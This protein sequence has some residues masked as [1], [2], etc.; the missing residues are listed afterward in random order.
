MNEISS[1]GEANNASNLGNILGKTASEQ[2]GSHNTS[3]NQNH[4]G[5][6]RGPRPNKKSHN[7]RPPK[8]KGKKNF[9]KKKKSNAPSLASQDKSEILLGMAEFGRRT[10]SGN[11][12][13]RVW[14]KRPP[15]PGLPPPLKNGALRIIT[16][17][18]MEA[19]G[20]NCHLV[21][22][23]NDIVLIDMG[24][25]FPDEGM[26]GIDY[27][28]PD[29]GYLKGKEK[30]VKAVIVTHGHLD[31]IGGIPHLMPLIGVK[32]PIYGLPMTTALILKRQEEFK[33]KLN[34]HTISDTDV[35]QHGKMRIEFFRVNHNIPDSMGVAITTPAGTVINTG[36]WKIDHSPVNEKPTDLSKIARIGENNNVLAAMID[37][38]SAHKEGYQISESQIMK[39]LE[40]IFMQAEGRIIT[41]T[42]SSL[43]SRIQQIIAL[44]A[45]VGRKVVLEGRSM[46]ENVS[47]A[48]NL[49]YMEV[50]KGT[51][52]EAKDM[53]RYPPEK[54]TILSTGAQGER[55]AA[56]SR[57]AKGEHQ[58]IK[59]EPGDTV[60]FSSSY[61]PGNEAAIQSLMDLI[62]RRKANV[63]H[64]KHMDIHA[65]GH[66]K[67]EETKLLLS[68]LK[69]KV[70]IPIHGS[71][72]LLVLTSQIC[73]QVGY[74]PGENCH[75]MDNGSV[76][77]FSSNGD[78]K[79]LAEK[80]PHS[81]IAV[82]GLGVGDVGESVLKDRTHMGADGVLL[83]LLRVDRHGN[84]LSDPDIVSRGFVFMHGANKLIDTMKE[85]IKQVCKEHA[86]L[87]KTDQK[88]FKFT[89][90]KELEK[91]IFKKIERE[92][93][94]IPIITSV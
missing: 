77:D 62:Y 83:A 73:R 38:T 19:I 54:L 1:P 2:I 36:D 56:L 23:E 31:H 29:I 61:I 15:K 27:S 20:R 65:G 40:P 94:V 60:I 88:E 81:L 50:P 71:H 18:G 25:Q 9:S 35:L 22:Y 17:G 69:P 46:K 64:Y 78:H 89:L 39:N 7:N 59:I 13:H 82:D 52:I 34:I 28:I 6:N 14:E 47:I 75:V 24:L 45:K 3:S 68:L 92:P 8:Q 80:A 21:E 32:V 30:N 70:V 16:L 4:K 12:K 48:S 74:V 37:S 5:P 33:E 42:F 66:A 11:R 85:F 57:I 41:G 43:L 72:S 76:V 10:T 84:L 51:L 49:H 90:Q 67:S 86:K 55:F 44:S 87:I 91:F 79:H 63:I 26:H 58:Q 93:M 53:H